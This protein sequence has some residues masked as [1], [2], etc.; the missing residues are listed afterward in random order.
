MTVFEFNDYKGF[1]RHWVSERPKN[2][3]GE[4][5]RFGQH[6]NV[7]S[8]MISQIFS[9]D[10][11]LNL[12]LASDLC[13][14]LGLS[15]P[16][17]DYFFLLLET[18]R[19]GTERLRKKLNK[20]ILESRA[21]AQRLVERVQRDK[22]LSPEQKA[23]YYSSWMYTGLRNLIAC[24]NNWNENAL[25][26]E[27]KI[28]ENQVRNVIK[29]L[30]EN[31]LLG[32]ENGRYV[33]KSKATH[34][35]ADNP[36]VAKHHQNWRFRGIQKMDWLEEKNLFYTGPMSLSEEDA[37]K[38]RGMLLELV[39]EINKLVVNSPSKTARCLNLDWFQI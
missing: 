30:T 2:G 4:F 31:N 15:D 22:E 18:A 26:Q 36:L 25:A 14:Y 24:E 23:I 33:V 37:L 13:D 20:R 21:K 27:L 29:F 11:H 9:G 19:A 1:V 5:R 6:L 3:R 12:E 32:F 8:T 7:S 39:Q 34:L 16:E 35:A 17:T 10:K 38:V 28:G